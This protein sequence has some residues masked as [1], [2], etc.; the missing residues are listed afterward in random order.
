MLVLLKLEIS[1][2]NLEVVAAALAGCQRGAGAV[3]LEGASAHL[4]GGAVGHGFKYGSGRGCDCKSVR[5][6][7]KTEDTDVRDVG[8]PESGIRVLMFR[9]LLFF[10]RNFQ[11]MLMFL[12]LFLFFL[13]PIAFSS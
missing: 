4:E 6:A 8:V 12:C 11:L 13:S 3:G 9:S 10:G 7:G 5:G 1:F 2:N